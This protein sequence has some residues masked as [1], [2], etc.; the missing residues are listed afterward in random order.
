M[1]KYI[2]ADKV[3]KELHLNHKDVIYI[4]KNECAKRIEK[5]KGIDLADYVPREF[6]DKT[7]EEM[8]RRHQAEIAELT[9]DRPQGEWIP[10]DCFDEWYGLAYKCNICGSEAIGGCD[11]FCP[12]CG[13]RMK[14]ADDDID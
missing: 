11:N 1:S 5:I 3:L 6:H 9:A 14:G 10:T 13:A 2:D 12:H 7:C 8:A 4:D